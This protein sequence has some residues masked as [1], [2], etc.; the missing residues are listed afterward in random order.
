MKNPELVFVQAD[1]SSCLP[2]PYSDGGVRA[3]FPSPS[4]DY[5]EKS[6][7]LNSEL[8]HN[9]AATFY[10]KVVGDSMIDAGIRPGDL[11]V[12]D[13]SVTP[14]SGNLAICVLNGEFTVKEL[15]LSQRDCNLIR[16]IP[17]N[18][19][20]SVIEVRPTDQFEVWG[21]VTYIIHKP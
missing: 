13:R 8:I 10:C 16:L 11:L 9:P 1:F 19:H 20:Y 6:L 18:D 12:V 14:Q 2:L 15:D 3:G 21:V 5:L 4:Q 17:R 7:D